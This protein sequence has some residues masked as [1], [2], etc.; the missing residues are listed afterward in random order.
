MIYWLSSTIL[1][2]PHSEDFRPLILRSISFRELLCS[3]NVVTSSCPQAAHFSTQPL[4]PNFTI[5]YQYISIINHKVCLIVLE[6]KNKVNGGKRYALRLFVEVK[7]YQRSDQNV[8]GDWSVQENRGHAL[9][10]RS[11]AQTDLN[12]RSGGFEKNAKNLEKQTGMPV[13]EAFL[14]VKEWCTRMESNHHA[15]AGTRT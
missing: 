15:I 6:C 2:S 14:I 13:S 5:V 9:A 12:G 3:R 8:H 1:L 11:V 7:N 4:I 10:N